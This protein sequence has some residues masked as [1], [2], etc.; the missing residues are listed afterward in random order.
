VH[1]ALVLGD[2][3]LLDRSLLDRGGLLL[4]LHLPE[5]KRKNT[6]MSI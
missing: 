5:N 3:G 2:G 1:G 4:V 6:T